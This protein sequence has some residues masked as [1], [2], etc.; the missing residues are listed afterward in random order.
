MN[1]EFSAQD[2]EFQAEVKAFIDENL[3]PDMREVLQR[4]PTGHLSKALQIEWQQRLAKKGWAVPNWPAEWGGPSWT[5]TQKY[6]FD[7]EMSKASAPRV[8]PFG[9][10]MVAPV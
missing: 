10:T 1:V 9:V 8:L 3:T 6:I 5:A 7:L 4:S 2:L